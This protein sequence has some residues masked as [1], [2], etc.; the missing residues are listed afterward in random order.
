MLAREIYLSPKE[1]V[2]DIPFKECEVTFEDEVTQVL[3]Y[4]HIIFNRYCWQLFDL[5]PNTPITSQCSILTIL[6]GELYNSD[7]HIKLL[8]SIFKHICSYNNLDAYYKKEP[9]LKKVYVIVNEIVNEIVHRVSDYVTTI[10][11]VDFVEVVNDE[12]IKAIHNSIQSKPES[13]ELSYKL[14][15]QRLKELDINNHFVHAYR[16]KAIN[17]NQANQG[18]GPRGFVTDL[19]RTV[20]QEPIR[21]GFIRGLKNL[22]EVITESR[23]AAKSLAANDNQIKISEY[24]SRRIQL[25]TMAVESI[26]PGDCGST[27][28]REFTLYDETHLELLKGIYY[29]NEENKLDYIRG[30]EKHLIGKVLHIRTAL[31]CRITHRHKI[32]STCLGKVSENIKENSNLGYV[33]TSY[34][35]E[36]STQAILSTKHL[37]HSVKETQIVLEGNAL[38]YFRIEDGNFF[39]LNP[40]LDTQNL[41]LMLPMNELNKLVDILNMEHTNVSL[42]KIGELSH[43]KFYHFK[44]KEPIVEDVNIS[45]KDRRCILTKEFL[46]YIKEEHLKPIERG[47][48][49]ID[50]TRF[51]KSNPIF[52]SPLKETNIISFVN[53]IASIVETTEVKKKTMTSRK[54]R[55]EDPYEKLLRLFYTIT[56]RTKCNFTILQIIIYATTSY[57]AFNQNYRLG[58]NSPNLLSASRSPLFRHRSLSQLLVFEEQM[59]EI[60]GYPEVIFSPNKRQRHPFD[61]LFCPTEAIHFDNT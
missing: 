15:K 1:S 61:V 5:Y 49:L 24:A 48:Y 20:F 30:N 47:N 7:T 39:Y 12:E 55:Y 33:S 14:I 37:T 51:D 36:K 57:D 16:S 59:N 50:L 23:T 34:V 45:Y 54:D 4:K 18:I 58:R 29:L 13:I 31:D 52:Y 41:Y 56:E 53:N 10:D 43:A 46:D 25:L 11:A 21:S 19:D 40:E 27:T 2:W 44:R 60:V 9:L 38:K 8:E 6:N 26:V 17:E 3:N 35:M 22:Y 42:P 32:C 28:F